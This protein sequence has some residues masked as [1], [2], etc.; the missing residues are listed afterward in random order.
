MTTVMIFPFV[1]QATVLSQLLILPRYKMKCLDLRCPPEG[2]DQ[3]WQMKGGSWEA[4]RRVAHCQHP[5]GAS[6]VSLHSFPWQH[7]LTKWK[8]MLLD[9]WTVKAST[10]SL[11]SLQFSAEQALNWYM[12]AAPDALQRTNG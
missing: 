1:F 3:R 10:M 11:P 7:W 5:P 6:L 4:R 12:L 8:C 9:T 2:E